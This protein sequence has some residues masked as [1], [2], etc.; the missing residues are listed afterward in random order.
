MPGKSTTPDDDVFSRRPNPKGWTPPKA[1]YNP[2][3]P[4]D[5]RPASGYP[6][7]FQLPGQ[8]PSGFSSLPR[9]PTQYQKVNETMER[10]NYTARPRSDLYPGQY[11]MLR[12]VDT[13]KKLH[14]GSRWF[15]TLITG[16]AVLYFTFFYRWNEGR[17]NVFTDLYRSQLWVKERLVGLTKQE[18]DDLHH[19]QASYAAIKGVK[20]SMYIPEDMR[21]TQE[22]AY[23]LN[24]P[25]ERHILEAE[26]I[27]Q[28]MEEE[29]LLRGD[30]LKNNGT[31]RK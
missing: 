22:G 21:R 2:Y 23:A 5:V 20:D 9:Q 1:P 3:D 12:R 27:Q 17:D 15:G 11:K 26:R 19:P 13:N 16:S 7:E 18:F 31:T 10:L 25:G 28:E 29:Q 14:L 6:S 8:Q 24:R 4:T 30:Y